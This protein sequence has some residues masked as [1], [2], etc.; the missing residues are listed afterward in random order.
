MLGFT[1]SL[2]REIGSRNITVNCVAPGY[3]QTEMTGSLQEEQLEAIQR[4]SPLGLPRVEDAAAAV[5]YLLSADAARVTG[6]V[7]TVDGGSTA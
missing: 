1:K 5:S 3:M 6:T 4:R 2:A 7:I